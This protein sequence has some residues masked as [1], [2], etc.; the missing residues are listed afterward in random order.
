MQ[1][2]NELFQ[3]HGVAKK[4]G[5]VIF[6]EYEPGNTLFFLQDGEVRLTK[7]ISN[8][9]KILADI[10][11]GDIFGEMAILEARPRSATCV[12]LTDVKMLEFDKDSFAFLIRQKPEIAVKLLREFAKRIVDQRRKFK[13]LNLP[14]NETRVLDVFLFFIEQTYHSEEETIR[15]EIEL[16]I[17]VNEVASWAGISEEVCEGVLKTLARTGKIFYGKNKIRIQNMNNIR[18]TV[19]SKRKLMASR[20]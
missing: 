6:C 13:I 4:K 18:L 19:E 17:N 5:E 11:Y 10:K 3:K 16:N 7:I 15:K 9:E 8:K 12:A 1:V 14:D 20:T 2:E